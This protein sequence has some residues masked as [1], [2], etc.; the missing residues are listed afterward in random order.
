MQRDTSEGA[1]LVTFAATM[2]GIFGI[3]NIFDGILA[4]S[5]SSFYTS[6]ATYVFS[7][8]KTWGWI[9]LVLGILQVIASFA[10]F[11]GS[12]WGRWFGVFCAAANAFG[13]LMFVPAYPFW[14]LALFAVD[15]VII[16]GLTA[17]A[18]KPVRG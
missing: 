18:G 10:I 7:D 8:I 9:I 3:F 16:Y 14:G 6:H 17:Y 4:L 1:G 13:Q 15:I 11:S 2:L 5:K 12:Q